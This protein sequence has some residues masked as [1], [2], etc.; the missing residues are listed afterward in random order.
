MPKSMEPLEPIEPTEP[1]DSQSGRQPSQP[2]RT[3]PPSG[4]PAH[5]WE[6]LSPN[7]F[8]HLFLRRMAERDE[9]PTAG[10]ADVQG[11]W[12]VVAA[13][14]R[15]Y[16]VIRV[17][18]DLAEGDRPT[19]VFRDRSAA[20]LAAAVLPATGREAAYRLGYEAEPQG[21]PLWADGEVAGHL[22]LFDETLTQALHVVDRIAR[23][24]LS[25][26]ALLEAAG[27]LALERAGRILVR[28]TKTHPAG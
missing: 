12:R 17:G 14:G 19:A 22:Q 11:P 8:A 9:P 27:G 15:G 2:G 28:Q 21:Y 10:E 26:A 13:P 20:L 7:A 3:A 23:S 4:D 1:M 5:P 24:P 16:A 6:A 25:L 18:E